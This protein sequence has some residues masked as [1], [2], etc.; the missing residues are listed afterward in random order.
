MR[1][2]FVEKTE[3]LGD[4]GR[5]SRKSVCVPLHVFRFWG[6]HPSKTTLL[7]SLMGKEK[8][9]TCPWSVIFC[10]SKCLKPRI[11]LHFCSREQCSENSSETPS[12]LVDILIPKT[13]KPYKIHQ[14]PYTRRKNGSPLFGV[15]PL[16]VPLFL[17]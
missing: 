15:L 3:G 6:V 11:A 16:T 5:M 1:R 17:T 2:N 9:F 10:I 8:P 7:K 12:P 4:L 13:E 14:D